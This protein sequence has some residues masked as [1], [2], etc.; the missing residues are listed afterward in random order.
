MGGGSVIG[1]S[2]VLK[3]ELQTVQLAVSALGGSIGTN[4]ATI[5]GPIIVLSSLEDADRVG[6]SGI[7]GKIVVWNKPWTGSYGGTVDIRSSGASKAAQYGALASLT[8]SVTPFSLY[9]LH[10][11][12]NSYNNASNMIPAAAITVEDAEL[13]QRMQDRGQLANA[14]L[15]LQLDCT[16][17]NQA[18]QSA[19]IVAELTGSSSS[20]RRQIIVVGGHTDSWSRG[21]QDDGAGFSIAWE[22][23]NLLAQMKLRPRRT[24]RLVG[25]T[26]EEIGGAGSRAYFAQYLSQ[27]NQTVM[28]MEIDL[29][30]FAPVALSFQGTAQAQATMQYICDTLL[31]PTFNLSITPGGAGADT[32]PLAAAGVPAA[33][34][35]VQ[36]LD[37]APNYWWYHHAFADCST[38]VQI[39]DYNQVLAVVASLLFVLADMPEP[40]PRTTS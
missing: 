19:N 40:L 27:V 1:A 3:T 9:S 11:G 14:T 24:I 10:T 13:L 2:L 5:E 31:S 6:R 23:L 18:G 20:G 25:W 8:R 17:E 32:A 12:L 15:A 35:R 38:A 29:G 39:D 30:I 33:G 21:A 37:D 26:A 36:T 22:A 4:G 7:E 34:I 28:A 16:I